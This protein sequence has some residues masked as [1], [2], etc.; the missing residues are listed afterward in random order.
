MKPRLDVPS[1]FESEDQFLSWTRHMRLANQPVSICNDCTPEY[2]AEMVEARRCAHHDVTFHL[3][4]GGLVGI[5]PKAE[6]P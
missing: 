6:E 3:Q 1:C 4:D 2:Q 5:H